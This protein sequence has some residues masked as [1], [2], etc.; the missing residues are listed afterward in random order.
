MESQSLAELQRRVTGGGSIKAAAGI[1]IEAALGRL[2]CALEAD[3]QRKRDLVQSLHLV[4]IVMPP[5]IAPGAGPANISVPDAGGPHDGFIWDVRRLS[6]T[7]F[8]AGS[9]TL[10]VGPPGAASAAPNTQNNIATWNSTGS[11]FFSGGLL[12]NQRDHLV[13]TAAGI[14]GNV[15]ITGMAV[16]MDADLLGEYLL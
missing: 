12:L 13:F 16:E 8:T 2:I 7:G 6:A 4:P 3:R 14:T 11:F 9:V 1:G 10:S 5:L 15:L